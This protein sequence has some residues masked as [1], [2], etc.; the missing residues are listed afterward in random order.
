MRIS[1]LG[2]GSGLGL[3]VLLAGVVGACG[4][5]ADANGA[6]GEDSGAPPSFPVD[7]EGG[8]TTTTFDV[9]PH[10]L[11]TITVPFGQ[12]APTVTFTATGASGEPVKVGWDVD[13]G[14]IGSVN[15]GPETSTVFTPSGRTGGVVEVIARLGDQA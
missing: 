9:Q 5:D 14:E 1:F 6:G 3:A 4:S 12:H 7:H 15:A 11:Q 8:S 13:R 10:E 2:W